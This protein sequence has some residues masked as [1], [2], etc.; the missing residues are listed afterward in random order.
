MI[1]DQ[2]AFVHLRDEVVNGGK[3]APS[4]SL[5]T[6]ENGT[7]CIAQSI[8]AGLGKSVCPA[9]GC[10]PQII[11]SAHPKPDQQQGDGDHRHASRDDDG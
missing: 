11:H 3:E 6:S 1:F 4:P 10:Q 7:S 2:A 5:S 9:T 8:S